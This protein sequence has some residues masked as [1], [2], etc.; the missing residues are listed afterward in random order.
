MATPNADEL[1]AEAV[2]APFEGWDFSWA[3]DRA[4]VDPLPWDYAS[5]VNDAIGTGP[6]TMIDMGTGGGEM[7]AS[8]P[9]RPV[10][11]WATE[12]W[13]PNVPVAAWRL[14]PLG[15]GVV[16]VEGARN[17]DQ[18]TH[19]YAGVG[20][21][22]PFRS[23]SLDLVINK[24]EAYAPDEVAR[25]L[26]TD[27]RFITQQVG[28]ANDIDMF[29]WFGRDRPLPGWG[30]GEF[31]AQAESAGLRVLRSGEAF[32]AHRFRDVGALV[33]YLKAVPWVLDVDVDRDRDA[34]HRIHDV[35]KH[36]G[37]F[38]VTSH[39]LWFEACVGA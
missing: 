19:Q 31:V 9:A 24:H 22:L 17:N 32:P 27:G 5:I 26:A 29:D 15:V 33:Y 12:A 1:I 30:L 21:R 13:R 4:F 18:W 2:A 11:T 14:Q 16:Q 34:L 6:R 36:D 39:R 28:G 8:L 3:A 38:V 23:G 10:A 37:E 35:C 20:G 25:L 7:L